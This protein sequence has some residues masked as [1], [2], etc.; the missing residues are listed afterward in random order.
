MGKG[1]GKGARG[2]REGRLITEVVRTPHS[3]AFS[4]VGVGALGVTMNSKSD[5]L[6]L[7]LCGLDILSGNLAS[8]FLPRLL[9][10]KLGK[11][12]R[13]LVGGRICK[14][15][16]VQSSFITKEENKNSLLS[17]LTASIALTA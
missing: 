4:K 10:N 7:A 17:L 9:P 5:S 2:K 14:R 8:L 1:R 15:G 6:P 12:T 3:S 16:S 13:Y 11:R